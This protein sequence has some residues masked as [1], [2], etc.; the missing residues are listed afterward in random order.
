[1]ALSL[2]MY[3]YFVFCTEKLQA[4]NSACM[5]TLAEGF[6]DGPWLLTAAS[7]E[8]QTSV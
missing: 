5:Q 3:F 8:K 7:Q 1:M 6:A 2:S 4:Q